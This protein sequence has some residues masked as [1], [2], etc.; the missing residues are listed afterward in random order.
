MDFRMDKLSWVMIVI[1]LALM[2]FLIG[3]GLD[4]NLPASAL[5]QALG[6]A[7]L[8]TVALIALSCIPVLIYCYFV[9]MIPDIDYSIRLA[10]VITVVGILSEFIF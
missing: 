5:P 10:F 2:I 7:L 6:Y 4:Y 9:K 1:M 8:T 3:G